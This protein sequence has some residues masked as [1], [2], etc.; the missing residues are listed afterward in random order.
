MMEIDDKILKGGYIIEV[1][2]LAY[3]PNKQHVYSVKIKEFDK[4]QNR[5]VVM[6]T[7]YDP[8]SPQ[9][10]YEFAEERLARMLHLNER[11]PVPTDKKPEGYK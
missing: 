4:I 9:K 8:E 7:G 1:R 10:A 2:Y 6:A 3:D 5:I 11:T